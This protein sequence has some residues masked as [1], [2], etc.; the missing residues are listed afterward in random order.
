M[1][2]GLHVTSV[3]GVLGRLYL[4]ATPATAVAGS[5]IIAGP[6]VIYGTSGRPA[7][8][9]GPVTFARGSIDRASLSDVP[10]LLDH[11]PHRPIGR[12]AGG[13][14]SD[15]ALVLSFE[16]AHTTAAD[17]AL[18]LV[19]A[20]VRTGLSVGALVTAYDLHP[21]DD[22]ADDV[23]LIVTGAGIREV[24]LVTFPA[25]A[26]AGAPPAPSCQTPTN[27]PAQNRAPTWPHRST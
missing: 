24:S 11:D 2:D 10:L 18:E 15:R 17:D 14:D 4:Q 1:L 5:R 9:P 19:R 16:L 13:H 3:P 20:R 27:P 12:I 6:A 25:Y 21:S 22:G 26:G 7:G 8:Y 23:E